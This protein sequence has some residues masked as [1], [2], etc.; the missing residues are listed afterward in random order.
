MKDWFRL[1]HQSLKLRPVLP[2]S[3][4][5]CIQITWKSSL[6]GLSEVSGP[7]PC[8]EQARCAVRPGCWGFDPG[9][10]WNLQGWGLTACP[11]AARPPGERAS[12]F[13][14][15]QHHSYWKRSACSCLAPLQRLAP[16]LQL[17]PSTSPSGGG[18]GKRTPYWRHLDVFIHCP[19]LNSSS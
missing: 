1:C 17:V 19:L 8:S 5:K 18:L 6:E 11:A 9:G 14:S 12:P 7:A 10:C 3:I 4:W 2:L 13:L 15:A 16:S